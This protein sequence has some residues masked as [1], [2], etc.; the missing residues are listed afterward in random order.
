MN[1][2][3]DIINYFLESGI[4]S[5]YSRSKYTIKLYSGFS[6]VKYVQVEGEGE[7][8]LIDR[9]QK[10]CWVPLEKDGQFLSYLPLERIL[11]VEIEGVE[12]NKAKQEFIIS[13][14]NNCKLILIDKNS[15]CV[16][17]VYEL[18][19]YGF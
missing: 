1:A 18:N 10:Y 13:F 16:N 11:E 3:N 12:Y 15:E 17:P 19:K 4:I 14:K 9:N 5:L 7:I 8:I 2:V 6:K